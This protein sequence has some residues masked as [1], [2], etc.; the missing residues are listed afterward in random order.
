MFRHTNLTELWKTGEMR[1]ETLQ[2]RAGHANIQTTMQMYI[3][4]SDEDI[5]ESLSKEGK[6][7]MISTSYNYQPTIIQEMRN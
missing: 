3:H 7:K 2:R 5:R 4:P 6:V 1:P